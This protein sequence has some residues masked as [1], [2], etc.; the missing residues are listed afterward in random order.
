MYT[1]VAAC[2]A[3]SATPFELYTSPPRTVL[4]LS[5]SGSGGGGQAPTLA[6]LK[7]VPAAM[8][9]L[10]WKAPPTGSDDSVGGYL[11]SELLASSSAGGKESSYSAEQ[12]SSAYPTGRALVPTAAAAQGDAVLASAQGKSSSVGANDE[13]GKKS[14][15]PKWLKF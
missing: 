10:S 1:W 15:K 7:L 4:P 13:S 6:D 9:H 5:S 2:L 8:V 11:C 14:F 3:L 12:P